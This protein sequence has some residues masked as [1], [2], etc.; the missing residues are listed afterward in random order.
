M[1]AAA[2]GHSTLGIPQATGK[3]FAESDPGGKLPE[4]AKDMEA[5]DW[6]GLL[7][8]L[9]KW[10]ME[11][12][13]EEEHE[14]DWPA[15]DDWSPEARAAAL[16][17]RRAK[18]GQHL[19]VTATPRSSGKAAF[20]TKAGNHGGVEQH[21]GAL[22]QHVKKNNLGPHNVSIHNTHTGEVHHAT[23]SPHGISGRSYGTE[24]FDG[25]GKDAVPPYR[26]GV[27]FLSRDG[28]VLLLKRGADE[29]HPGE[30]VFPGGKAR[31]GE[32]PQ[33]C[34]AREARE[35]VG[36]CGLDGLRRIDAT[37]QYVTFGQVCDQFEPELSGEHEEHCWCP[38]DQLPE[39]LHPEARKTLDR[40]REARDQD[41]SGKLSKTTRK[42]IDSPE[43]RED[44]P[45]SA[46]LGPDRSYPAKEKNDKGEWAYTRNL[47]L[48]SARRARM[49]GRTDI[50]RRA[51]AIREREFWPGEDDRQKPTYYRSFEPRVPL[52]GAFDGY[53]FDRSTNRT[54]DQEGRMHVDESNIS[55]ATINPYWGEEIPHYE[56]LGLEPKKKYMLLRDPEELAKPET[57]KSFNGLPLLWKHKSTSANDHPAGLVVGSTGTK[58][59]FEAPYLKNDVVIWPEH[60]N[61]AVED[62]EK[63]QLS[64]AYSYDADMTPGVFEGKPYDGVMRNIRGNHVAIVAEGRAGKDVMVADEA[65]DERRFATGDE[66]EPNMPK[67][68]AAAA[69]AKGSI[70]N[71]LRPRLAQDAKIDLNP[72]LEGVTG[73]NFRARKPI[74][75]HAIRTVTRGK[76]A[77]DA[78]IDDLKELLEQL[79]EHGEDMTTEPNSGAPM[80]GENGGHEEILD[81]LRDKLH[82]DHMSEVE[83]MMHRGSDDDETEEEMAER[84][85]WDMRARDARRKMGRDETPE[86]CE[87]REMRESAEDARRRMGRDETENE[88]MEREAY[89]RK[90]R[91]MR[92][93]HDMMRR[94]DDAMHQMRADD[95]KRRAE[96]KRRA[97]DR[98]RMADDKRMS[99]DMKMRADDAH[100]ARDAFRRARDECRAA[101]KRRAEDRKRM[102]DDWRREADDR[103]VAS[104]DMMYDRRR[105][106]RD[107]PPP[108]QGMPMTGVT[109][110][111]MDAAI[112]TAV[113][114]AEENARL[115]R[116]AERFVRPLVGELAMDERMRVPEDVY[117]AALQI[118]RVNLDGVH[119]SA[120]RAILENLPRG[121]GRKPLAM[122]AGP[123]KG[124]A[125]RFPEAARVVQM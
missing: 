63:E 82:P 115:V 6:R 23:V 11:E 39:G 104:M 121:D 32:S 36:D 9:F 84:G 49:Q 58:A 35:E 112:A 24:S 99:D 20:T 5:G 110:E 76:L 91:D 43:H 21:L 120:Y 10:I 26:S 51:D 48:A 37:D 25:W 28:K 105:G 98:A 101:D 85:G 89:D 114:T 119:P 124:F 53:A 123:S 81:Y 38:F 79:E 19:H 69:F 90:A 42:E 106:A 50:A 41:P 8:G 73:R 103:H 31:D 47:L 87:A 60:A 117:R 57:I 80:M 3:E 4:K 122:D 13:H 1:W 46:F 44:M 100:R 55:K 54:Y 83:D 88:K 78:D 125:E 71:Y 107:D 22:H 34:A 72:I 94:A 65:F 16:E 33:E 111:A 7:R 30:W 61:K 75:E 40:L 45:A 18:S 92:R 67:L 2:S 59:K 97:D 52:H 108:F 64:S 12:K 74:L 66:E 118:K 86:E 93:A 102:A 77:Q 109:K 62:G 70:L 96:D 116:E 113:A 17:A 56:E 68:S 95:R 27:V 14:E 29:H 15:N